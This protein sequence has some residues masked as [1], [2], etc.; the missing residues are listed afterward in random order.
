[1]S[2][3]ESVN[4]RIVETMKMGRLYLFNIF[5][6]AS[7]LLFAGDVFSA[8]EKE[9]GKVKELRGCGSAIHTSS[10]CCKPCAGK[11][12]GPQGSQSR[13]NEEPS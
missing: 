12:D 6:I 2:G 1:M 9:V 5:S 7:L 3:G 10:G 13:G 11:A 8:A 4:R